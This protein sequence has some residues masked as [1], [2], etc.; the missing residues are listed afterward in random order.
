MPRSVLTRSIFLTSLILSQPVWAQDW[1][2][3]PKRSS[4]GIVGKQPLEPIVG[5]VNKWDG[6]ILFDPNNLEASHVVIKV[7]TGSISMGD[8]QWDTILPKPDWLSAQDF[9]MATFEST[10]FTHNGGNAYEAVGT[11]TIRG[12][13]QNVTL[14]FNVDMFGNTAM[15]P[16]FCLW[17]GPISASAAC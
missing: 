12:I 10:S 15:P 3:D 8:H 4:V 17:F 11:L 9:P 1:A 14:P 13:K 2:V 6:T 5:T 16:A 7:D